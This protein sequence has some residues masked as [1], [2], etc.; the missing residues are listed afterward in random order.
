MIVRVGTVAQAQSPA[1]AHV[2]PE[3]TAHLC[4]RQDESETICLKNHRGL[5]DFSLLWSWF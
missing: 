5:G 4:R 2:V 1:T 3:L